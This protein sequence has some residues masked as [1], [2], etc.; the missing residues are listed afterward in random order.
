MVRN[1]GSDLKEE[2]DE[3]EK[4][5]RMI[6]LLVALIAAIFVSEVEP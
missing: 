3:D 2:R 1:M 5:S 4:M 6:M